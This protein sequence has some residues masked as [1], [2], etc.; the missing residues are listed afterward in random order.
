MTLEFVVPRHSSLGSSQD[1]LS[2]Q[3]SKLHF[4]GRRTLDFT[5]LV[6]AIHVG[7]TRPF[8]V[9]AHGPAL[10]IGRIRFQ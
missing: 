1:N 2:N 5:A 6:S 4:G 7:G 9:R 3:A 8:L 10:A